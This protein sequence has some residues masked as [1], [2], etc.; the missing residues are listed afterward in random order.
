MSTLL[1][2]PLLR[3]KVSLGAALALSILA[4]LSWDAYF[5]YRDAESKLPM[6][7][8]MQMARSEIVHFDE[9]LTMSAWMAAASG[10]LDWETRYRIFEPQLD[11]SVKDAMLL[12]PSASQGTGASATDAANL[13]LV[14]M[15]RRAFEL[16]RKG[17]N[18][19]AQRL[20]SSL[21]YETQ[22]KVYAAGMTE[23]SLH[24]LQASETLLM[25]LQ[26]DNRRSAI[27]TIAS[28]FVLILGGGFLFRAAHRWQAIVAKSNEQLNQRTTELAVLN[29]RL[30]ES[31]QQHQLAAERS[32]YLAYNDSLTGLPNRSMFSRLL[33][34]AISVS[35]RHGTQLAVLF[36]DLDRF[37]NVNDTLGHGAGDALLQEMAARFKS[38]LRASDS[39]ARLG[40]DEFVLVTPDLN[41]L[42]QV[43]AL[44]Q[45]VL[46]TVARPFA[47]RGHEF[48]VTASIGIAVYP[49]DGEDERVLMKNADIAM[50]QAKE[51]GK[52]TFAFYSAALNKH[53]VERLAFESSLRRALE[54]RQ[55]EVHYQPKVDCSTGYLTGVEALLRWNH[56]DLGPVPPSKFIPVAEE[57]GLIVSIG[58]WVLTTACQQHMAWRALGYPPLRVAVNLSARQFYDGSLLSDVR[59]T[60]AATGMDAEFLE[61]EI[62]ES[63]LMHDIEKASEVLMAFKNLGIRLSLDDFGTGY[64]SLSNLKRFPI[65]TIKVDRSFVRDLPANDEDKAIMD[66]VIAMGKTLHMTVVAE[67]V[68]TQGQI[69]F[70]RGLDCDECQGFYFSKAV[71]AEAIAELLDAKPWANAGSE[72]AVWGVG[73]ERTES[74]FMVMSQ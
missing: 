6:I 55:L 28:A 56:P 21:E 25:Q 19:E 42:E 13:A 22:K 73:H 32:E 39:V 35:Q 52:N 27:A 26:A 67:G 40:G 53:S 45:K 65:D 66:A 3:L 41:G 57:N 49:N 1:S 17:R 70:L 15:E 58:R 63:M 4:W 34:Q 54:E 59:S 71:Q 69:D 11:R 14:E 29:R 24:L 48:H 10:N 37:K 44:A 16:V 72:T 43:L 46:A 62:T 31:V 36:V 2:G 64:S 68:E 5:S 74:S 50:Y 8:R 33:H 23:F 38:C 30:Q 60:L 61:L 9:V 7:S 18:I 12:D 20:L 47:L 51:D